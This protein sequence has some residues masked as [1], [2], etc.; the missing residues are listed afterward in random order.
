MYDDHYKAASVVLESPLP[1]PTRPRSGVEGDLVPA[2]RL[3]HW[4]RQG[5]GRF[6]FKFEIPSSRVEDSTLSPQMLPG[7][8]AQ[9][10]E[11]LVTLT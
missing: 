3:P 8:E 9:R 10:L 2:L 11:H 4:R 1:M 5:G 6:R 7:F